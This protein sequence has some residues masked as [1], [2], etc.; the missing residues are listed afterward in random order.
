MIL[1]AGVGLDWYLGRL[2][3]DLRLDDGH[4]RLAVLV[5]VVVGAEVAAH[6]RHQLLGHRDLGWLEV[7]CLVGQIELID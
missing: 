2:A 3:G 7:G 1:V 5:L 4:Q 6:G